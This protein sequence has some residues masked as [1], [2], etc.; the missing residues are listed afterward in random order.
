MREVLSA[1]WSNDQHEVEL[2]APTYLT[3][4]WAGQ[5]SK[6]SDEVDSFVR[7]APIMQI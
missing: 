7:R 1:P 3:L 6:T 5:D 2:A 4:K